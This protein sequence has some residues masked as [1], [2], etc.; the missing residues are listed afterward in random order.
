MMYIIGCDVDRC[1]SSS[2][3]SPLYDTMHIVL[4]V[5]FAQRHRSAVAFHAFHAFHGP[6]FLEKKSASNRNSTCKLSVCE[7]ENHHF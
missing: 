5:P 4:T 3:S 2:S 7:L 6:R 1:T